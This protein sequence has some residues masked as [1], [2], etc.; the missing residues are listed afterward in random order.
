ME[1]KGKVEDVTQETTIKEEN[2]N[3][4]KSENSEQPTTIGVP[5]CNRPNTKKKKRKGWCCC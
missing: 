2:I 4:S 3:N 5:I 1:K